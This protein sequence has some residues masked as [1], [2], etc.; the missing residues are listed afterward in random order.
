MYSAT[1]YNHSYADSG[2]FCIHASAPP[3]NV[4]GIV[5]VITKELVNMATQP[6]SQELRRAKTQLQ[7][8]LLMNL[9]ARPVVF[10]DIGRQVLANGERKRPEHFINEIGKFMISGGTKFN[11]QLC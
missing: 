4:R 5:E 6:G 8:M 10:E 2:I 1:A 11:M 7:S 3:A 9:E